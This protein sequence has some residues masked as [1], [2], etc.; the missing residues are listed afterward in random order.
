M[1]VII[2]NLF[3][4]IIY[5]VKYNTK[6]CNNTM[7]FN[8][9]ELAIL[10][11]AVDKNQIIMKTELVS[12]QEIK[13]ILY[14]LENFLIKNKNILYGG[15]ALNNILP[16]N[17]QFYD[18]NID[19]PDYDF[20]SYDA[21][22]DAKNICDIYYKN[23][24]KNVEGKTAIH[25]GTYKVY[26]NGYGVADITMIPKPLFK[27]LMKNSIKIAGLIYCPTDFLQMSLYSELSRPHGDVDRWEKVFKRL[28]IFNKYYPIP[29]PS[30]CFNITFQRHMETNLDK[31]EKIYNI[32]RNSFIEQNVV[33]FGG[34]GVSLYSKYMSSK[35][36]N[37][38][39]K[40]PD[41][42][43]LCEDI[44]KCSD[45]LI[46]NLKEY[47]VYSKK[48]SAIGE[49]IPKHIQIKLGQEILAIIYEPIA[50]HSFNKINFENFK[51]NV[52]TIDTILSFYLAFLYA[53]KDYFPKDRLLCMANF[54][55]EVEQKNRLEQ[56]GL[57]KRFSMNCYGHQ[58]TLEEMREKKNKYYR[59]LI[60]GS[61]EYEEWFFKYNPANKK[62]NKKTIKSGLDKIFN[63]TNKNKTKF[64]L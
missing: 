62:S 5:M 33:F 18:K 58:E 60:Q 16:K 42:D 22:K 63:K 64:T 20:F 40:I 21:I 15:T 54:L 6:T 19:L 29:L 41:F 59:S 57:L 38:I 9:C 28:T 45:I 44:N 35:Q 46:D 26:V 8:D 30:D 37:I 47:N 32:I 7:S 24:Y 17:A 53:D 12:N 39:K 10:R 34:F 49:I 36:Q 52:A 51:V 14:I 23:G 48:K 13:N 43:V 25:H 56:K 27:S 61:K 3:I 50:C 55:F 1:N 4:I 2:I 11:E 31:T